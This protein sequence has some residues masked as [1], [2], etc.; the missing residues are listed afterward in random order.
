MAGFAPVNEK[1][2]V[3]GE[4]ARS[5][6]VKTMQPIANPTATRA[7]E[8]LY[9]LLCRDG[10]DAPSKRQTHMQGHLEFIERHIQRIVIAGP[11]L[12]A[13]GAIEGSVLIVRADS[14]SDARNLLALDP[15]YRNGVWT[16]INVRP[17]RAVCGQALG[18]TT[19]APVLNPVDYTAH[20]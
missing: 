2:P 15:Y 14:E 11:A 13:A 8:T 9:L 7:R 17:F 19:W 6:D 12:N 1:H 3:R 10:M 16:D 5:G 18:G 20:S 4:T